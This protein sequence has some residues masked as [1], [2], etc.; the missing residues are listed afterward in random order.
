MAKH[1]CAN[2]QCD[3]TKHDAEEII[4]TN[5]NQ[6]VCNECSSVLIESGFMGVN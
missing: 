6:P 4:W 3:I 5:D 2:C 1:G